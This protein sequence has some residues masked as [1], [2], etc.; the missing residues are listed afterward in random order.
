MVIVHTYILM[1]NMMINQW[2]GCFSSPTD[3][4]GRSKFRSSTWDHG[5]KWFFYMCCLLPFLLQPAIRDPPGTTFL[6]P[7]SIPM[8]LLQL[9]HLVRKAVSDLMW[10]QWYLNYRLHVELRPK[11]C[12]TQLIFSFKVV[13]SGFQYHFTTELPRRDSEVRCLAVRLGSQRSHFIWIQDVS[14]TPSKLPSF[15][16]G[17]VWKWAIPWTLSFYSWQHNGHKPSNW[18]GAKKIIHSHILK[19]VHQC[20]INFGWDQQKQHS[21]IVLWSQLLPGFERCRRVVAV[22]C[23]GEGHSEKL[24]A[25]LSWESLM[26]P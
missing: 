8:T 10:Y 7:C 23:Q 15:V 11:T 17:L 5:A 25:G 12:K 3:F 26:A 9:G 14:T 18:G 1:G 2:T 19:Y 20:T 22:S 24:E 13:Q 6:E 4:L 16:H 21:I